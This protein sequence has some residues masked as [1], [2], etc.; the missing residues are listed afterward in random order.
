M[1]RAVQIRPLLDPIPQIRTPKMTQIPGLAPRTPPDMD[2]FEDPKYPILTSG[3][4]IMGFQVVQDLTRPIRCSQDLNSMLEISTQDLNSKIQI[5]D[6][7]LRVHT[8]TATT[9]P[10]TTSYMYMLLYREEGYACNG[11]IELMEYLTTRCRRW[12]TYTKYLD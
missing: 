1:T 7:M 9:S 11:S 6:Y 10:H 2:P 3:S 12:S 8:P 4:L 5:S